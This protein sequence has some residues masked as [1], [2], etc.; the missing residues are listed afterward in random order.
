MI[1]GSFRLGVGLLCIFSLG[2]ETSVFCATEEEI[3]DFIDR[4]NNYLLRG[5][6]DL[7]IQQLDQ[8]VSAIRQQKPNP[9]F[10]AAFYYRACAYEAKNDFKQSIED[11]TEAIALNPN[12]LIARYRRGDLYQ[13][14]GQLDDALSDY[15]EIVAIDSKQEHA[16]NNIGLVY[17]R[18]GDC[19]KAIS[20]F[21]K[22]LEINPRLINA[23]FNRGLAYLN[24]KDYF[25]AYSDFS[26]ELEISP[27]SFNARHYYEAVFSFFHKDYQR[28]WREIYKLQ[29]AGFVVSPVFLEELKKVFPEE[30]MQQQDLEQESV[31]KRS[32]DEQERPEFY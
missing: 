6:L 7:A 27:T 12:Y 22:A 20:Q 31:I 25:N 17:L 21:D 32:W 9:K 29:S 10:A 13:K 11:L 19:D 4:G 3:T 1:S 16:Y 2:V 15:L 5:Q 23:H 26:K 8:A 14:M 18:Q 30:Q 28:S 24:K